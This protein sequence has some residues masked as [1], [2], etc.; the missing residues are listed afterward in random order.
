ME[1]RQ[2]EFAPWPSGDY[3]IAAEVDETVAELSRRLGL[4][5]TQDVE[6]G[7]GE[8]EAV[9]LVVGPSAVQLLIVTY[10]DS[11]GCRTVVHVDLRCEQSAVLDALGGISIRPAT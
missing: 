2:I 7:L 10:L 1:L 11:P 5:P 9:E 6:E 8:I 4:H 3:R